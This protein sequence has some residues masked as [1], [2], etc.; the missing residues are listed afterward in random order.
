MTEVIQRISL[1]AQ[2]EQEM[3]K[4]IDVKALKAYNTL[5]EICY[6]QILDILNY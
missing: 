2:I 3:S 5:I 1:I 6:K 4:E